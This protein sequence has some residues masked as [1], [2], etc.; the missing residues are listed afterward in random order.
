MPIEAFEGDSALNS[1]NISTDHG[2]DDF[3]RFVPQEPTYSTRINDDCHKFFGKEN[4]ALPCAILCDALF[5]VIFLYVLW[6]GYMVPFGETAWNVVSIT[7]VTADHF[8]NVTIINALNATEGLQTGVPTYTNVTN[9]T[10]MTN[11]PSTPTNETNI[12]SSL[13]FPTTPFHS[14]A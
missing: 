3:F 10:S 1:A 12:H 11:L 14:I 7:N 2:G 5:T 8:F 6:W 4:P 9:A 13:V